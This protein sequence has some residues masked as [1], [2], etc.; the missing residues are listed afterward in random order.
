MNTSGRITLNFPIEHEGLPIQ[1]TALRRLTV[2][3]H[4]AAQKCKGEFVI[5]HP[6]RAGVA[7]ERRQSSTSRYC[8]GASPIFL[9]SLG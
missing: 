4:L 5:T 7:I 8:G 9:T 2:G 1:E 6:L 3:Y